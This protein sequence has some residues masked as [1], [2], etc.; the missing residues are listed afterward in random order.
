LRHRSFS[1]SKTLRQWIS[2]EEGVDGRVVM[3]RIIQ[4]D[5]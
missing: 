5:R 4:K 3:T 2:S 1:N